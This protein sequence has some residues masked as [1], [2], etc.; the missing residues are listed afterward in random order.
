MFFNLLFLFS[1]NSSTILYFTKKLSHMT[2][3]IHQIDLSSIKAGN[4]GTS[5]QRLWK[6]K[7]TNGKQ[8]I[9]TNKVCCNNKRISKYTH[10]YSNI[11]CTCSLQYIFMLCRHGASFDST[12]Y[13]AHTNTNTL[14]HYLPFCVALFG[15]LPLLLRC[16]RIGLAKIHAA[17][18]SNDIEKPCI[19]IGLKCYVYAT[20]HGAK[21]VRLCVKAKYCMELK[22][23]HM[24]NNKKTTTSWKYNNHSNKQ[25][26]QW[27]I[28]KLGTKTKG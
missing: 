7:P 24:C 20:V 4:I 5:K 23:L 25:K 10:K 16:L 21:Q 26:G 9:T 19:R 11:F 8:E 27:Q 22:E 12:L 2:Y 6:T 13:T 28:Q 18:S 1:F 17:I 3:W 15:I 14:T